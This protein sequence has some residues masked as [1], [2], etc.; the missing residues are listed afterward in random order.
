MDNLHIRARVN[1]VVRVSV[2]VSIGVSVR[3]WH[4]LAKGSLDPP[5]PNKSLSSILRSEA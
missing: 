2:G 3:V 4:A 5:E 1:V